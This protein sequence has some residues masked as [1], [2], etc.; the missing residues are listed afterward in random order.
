[1]C[2]GAALGKGPFDMPE[3]RGGCY[4]SMYLSVCLSVCMSV[5]LSVYISIYVYVY[6]C[7]PFCV[8]VCLCVWLSIYSYICSF[9]A[10]IR[11]P[12]ESLSVAS[13]IETVCVCCDSCARCCATSLPLLSCCQV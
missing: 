6:V 2:G 3:F 7:E 5:Y 8:S 9:S 10:G 11:L 1:M 13:E 12:L 4:R